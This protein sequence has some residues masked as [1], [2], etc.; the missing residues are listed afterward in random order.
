MQRWHV[1]K[2]D[3]EVVH[4]ELHHRVDVPFF[5]TAA[6][7]FGNRIRI[8]VDVDVDPAVRI[9]ALVDERELY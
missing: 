1:E 6:V 9:L 2:E 7:A 8:Y 5:G 3:E 4:Q